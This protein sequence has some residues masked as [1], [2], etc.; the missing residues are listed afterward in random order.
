MKRKV[1]C[2]ISRLPRELLAAALARSFTTPPEAA[3][4][5][6][7]SR[8]FRAAADSDDVWA[9]FLPGDLPPLASGE[10]ELVD[11][12]S[13]PPSSKKKKEMFL[14]LTDHPVLLA[15]GFTSLR[16]DKKTGA[17][18][19][20]LSA[21]ALHICGGG[22]NPEL[23]RWIPPITDCSSRFSECAQLLRF[24]ILVIEGRIRC[25]MLSKN[26][27]YGA[28]IVFK[29]TDKSF[30]LEYPRFPPQYA[31]LRVGKR[32]IAVG[33]RKVCLQALP[34]ALA[35]LIEGPPR[36][37]LPKTRAD[38]WMELEMAGF[39]VL[40]GDLGDVLDVRLGLLQH[41]V[42]RIEGLIV[43]GIEIRPQVAGEAWFSCPPTP[44]LLLAAISLT[45][46]GDACR[47]AAVCRAFRAAADSDVVWS[48][49]F[50]HDLPPLADG[51]LSR[52]LPSNKGRFVHLAARPVILADGL[53]S[54]WL[55]RETGVKCFM[56]SARKL[57]IAWDDT[58]F[59]WRWIPITG[60]SF[61]EAAELRS[62][63]WLEILGKIDSKML[64]KN[65]TYSVYL[66]FKVAGEAYGLQHPEQNT[67]VRL[68][69]IRSS[70]RVCLDGRLKIPQ[71]VL[72]PKERADG[73]K[74]VE[75]GVFRN[76]EG[77]DALN[78]SHARIEST[79]SGKGGKGAEESMEVISA[80]EIARLPEELLS[81]VISRTAPRDACRAAAVS[82]AFRAAADSDA[83]WSCF[84]PHDLPPL[85]DGEL[86]PAP[87]SN[88][89]LFMRLSGGPVLLADG[90][91][92][93]WLDRESG[94]KCYMLSARALYIVWGDTPEYWSWIPLTD[95][96][97]QEW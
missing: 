76:D 27:N 1:V 22:D 14:R 31:T 94:A 55:D 6:I 23:W 54:M 5:A 74:E 68:G 71:D 75:L 80:C 25:G 29:V 37:F 62:V 57:N 40:E 52:A 66:V 65:S 47:A 70:R 59:Y 36:R 2:E 60:C 90:L 50:P 20:M 69:G 35:R 63:C 11:D 16:L 78:Q 97:E 67:S 34:S 58:P 8:D 9:N 21:R 33:R 28:Y 82:P 32:P 46:P 87:L 95:S 3:R 85:A 81:V 44:E 18:C 42:N 19:Y 12:D 38:G 86:H 26:T 49:F 84:L 89:E 17:K 48:R 93:M 72:L 15:N 79:E 4:A 64:S 83:V 43:Q 7:V 96:S 45:K 30:G 13:A 56:L 88:K 41:R 39:R 73:W 53:T 10:E 24:S 51:E 91:M 61:S 77:E 92:S